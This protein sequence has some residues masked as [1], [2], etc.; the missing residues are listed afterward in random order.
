MKDIKQKLV[1]MT[2]RN[3]VIVAVIMLMY[4]L[5]DIDMPHAVNDI[6]NSNMGAGVIV[7]SVIYLFL[8]VNNPVMTV[9]AVIA[10]YELMRRAKHSYKVGRVVGIESSRNVAKAGGSSLRNHQYTLEEFVAEQVVE[11]DRKQHAFTNNV[12]PVC[13]APNT[14]SAV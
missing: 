1:K 12:E 4:I 14:A 3:D 10:V 2:K 11:N 6:I 9:L 5:V 7:I 8:Q 13:S